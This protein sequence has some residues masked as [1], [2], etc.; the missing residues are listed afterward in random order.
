MLDVVLGSELLLVVALGVS[1]D[2]PLRLFLLNHLLL[3]LFGFAF[4]LHKV[5]SLPLQL[6][7]F[8]AIDMRHLIFQ[9]VLDLL[10]FAE[11]DHLVVLSF[12]ALL[13]GVFLYHLTPKLVLCFL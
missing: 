10:V 5:F 11:F 9:E 3:E 8:L 13:T 2:R 6:G 12:H 4:D 7:F 1:D